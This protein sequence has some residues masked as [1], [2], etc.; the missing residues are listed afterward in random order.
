MSSQ[1]VARRYATALADVL[2][3]RG[4]QQA[5]LEEL[6]SW[7][8]MILANPQLTEV[9]ENPTIPYEQKRRVLAELIKST[10][11]SEITANFLRVLLKNQRLAALPQV[12]ERLKG[13]L[14]ARANVVAAQVTTA[15]PVDEEIKG[16][17]REKLARS[18]G[19]SVRLDFSVDDSLIGGIVTRIGSTVYDG[20]IKNQLERMEKVLAGG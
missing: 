8:S 12:N 10:G 7:E 18:T 16:M 15:K 19:K 5:I 17:L 14:D 2:I 4:Q 20:S 6:G 1:T 9:F 11:I 3:E 13:V